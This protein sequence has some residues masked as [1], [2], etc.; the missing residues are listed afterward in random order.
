MSVRSLETKL[1]ERTLASR[2]SITRARMRHG[3]RVKLQVNVG[4]RARTLRPPPPSSEPPC[5]HAPRRMGW[6]SGP[7]SLRPSPSN[8]TARDHARGAVRA[9]WRTEMP[10]PLASLLVLHVTRDETEQLTRE[11]E[12]ITLREAACAEFP[13]DVL[14]ENLNRSR[15]GFGARRSDGGRLRHS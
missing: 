10:K 6:R 5:D 1:S 4:L 3:E 7:P 8:E 13:V 14:R 9:G 15:I 12:H 2:Q 11:G